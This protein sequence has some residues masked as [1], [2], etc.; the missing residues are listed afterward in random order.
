MEK[1]IVKLR[2]FPLGIVAGTPQPVSNAELEPIATG[3]GV[4]IGLD[5][6]RG[7]N[8]QSTDGSLREETM[9]RH[10]EDISQSVLTIAAEDEC[11][12]EKA[13]REVIQKYRAPRTVYATW[14]SNEKG[15]Q[16]IAKVCD[17][18]DGWR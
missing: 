12:V 7:A 3:C 14:G 9:N 10:I 16:I 2:Y 5:E 17:T 1:I 13:I 6:V 15:R 11:A 4:E 18:D 8:L